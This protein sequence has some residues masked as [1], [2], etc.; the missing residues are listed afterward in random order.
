MPAHPTT[1]RPAVSRPAA[2]TLGG[3]F[4]LL[5]INAD[6][7]AAHA[8]AFDRLRAGTLHAVV[9]HGVYPPSVLRAVIERLERHDPQFLKTFFPEKFKSWFFGRNVNL[10]HPDLP[11]Y[12]AES[13]KFRNQLESLFPAGLGPETRVAALLASLDHG[14]AFRAAPGPG[15][16]EAYMFTTLR[17]HLEGGYIPSHFDNE[18]ALRKSYRH[19][20]SLVELHM[21]SFVLALAAPDAGGEQEI[22]DLRCEPENATMLS[23]DSVRDKPDVS[24]L[25]SVRFPLPAGTMIVV[26]SGRYLHRLTPVVGPRKRWT[27]CSFMALARDKSATYCWG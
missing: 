21:L 19:L 14:R 25:A 13:A 22:F 26:D 18:Q 2:A 7:A 15:P 16:G 23:D 9:V 6:D 24:K 10:A 3:F 1:W 4:G 27:A 11:G 17:A 5:E 8:G 20:H 12:F